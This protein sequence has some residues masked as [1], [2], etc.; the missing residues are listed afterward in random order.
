MSY[1]IFIQSQLSG[2]ILHNIVFWCIAQQEVVE[3]VPDCKRR[4]PQSLRFSLKKTFL[5]NQ[6]L[7]VGNKKVLPAWL[8]FYTSP[9]KIWFFDQF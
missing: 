1:F 2:T 4:S 7:A 3:R 9:Q 8:H 5:E 6:S